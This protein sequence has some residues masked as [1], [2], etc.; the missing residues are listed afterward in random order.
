MKYVRYLILRISR[1]GALVWSQVFERVIT[2][3][4]LLAVYAASMLEYATVEPVFVVTGT[5]TEPVVVV[6]IPGVCTRGSATQVRGTQA[7]I[8]FPVF[9]T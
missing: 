6:T 2:E 3:R 5:V 8:F 1:V 4:N 9:V 7:N